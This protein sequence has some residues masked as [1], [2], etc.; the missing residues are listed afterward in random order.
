MTIG[1]SPSSLPDGSAKNAGD[2]GPNAS[3]CGPI[4]SLLGATM[5]GCLPCIMTSPDCCAADQAC[6]GTCE[7]LLQCALLCMQGDAVC[8]G[9]CENNWPTGLR[10]YQMLGQCL[11]QECGTQCPVL[12]Q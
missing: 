5:A 2:A 3:S 8:L 11:M 10:G 1:G 7:G 6:T 4:D 9:G 12:A